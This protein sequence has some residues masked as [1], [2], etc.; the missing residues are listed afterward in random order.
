M[1]K[2]LLFQRTGDG[3]R[4]NYVTLGTP[5]ELAPMSD[6]EVSN[7]WFVVADVVKDSDA[8][9][10]LVLTIPTIQRCPQLTFDAKYEVFR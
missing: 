5:E 2:V 1:K 4:F 7:V 8:I 6:K 10:G 3:M 9:E